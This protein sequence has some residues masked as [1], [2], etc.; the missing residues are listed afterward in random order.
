MSDTLREGASVTMPEYP[1]FS[2]AAE[3][4]LRDINTHVNERS[5]SW[6]RRRESPV[7]SPSS[8]ACI[9]ERSASSSGMPLFLR[10]RVRPE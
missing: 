4:S 6:L 10:G 5:A 8:G 3:Q 2:R 7:W 1:D 9:N